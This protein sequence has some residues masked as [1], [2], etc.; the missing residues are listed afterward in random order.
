[1]QPLEAYFA[2]LPNLTS[3]TFQDYFSDFSLVK[4]HNP[5]V[6]DRAVEFWKNVIIETSR[7]GLLG[8]DRC[9]I[10]GPES[11]SEKLEYLET[12]P[13]L[14]CVFQ[15]LY[16]SGLITPLHSFS[17]TLTRMSSSSFLTFSLNSLLYVFIS[18]L[19]STMSFFAPTP[20]FS[21][22]LYVMMPTLESLAQAVDKH[23]QIIT[24][25]KEVY[26]V[27]ERLFTLK[28]FKEECKAVVGEL[29]DKDWEVFLQYLEIGKEWI[30]TTIIDGV[31][32]IKF[33]PKDKT[34]VREITST[35]R[36]IISMKSTRTTLLEQISALEEQIKEA[37]RQAQKYIHRKQRLPALHRLKQ[38]KDLTDLLHKRQE[39]LDTLDDILLR[40]DSAAT[41]AEVLE[42]YDLGR[43]TLSNI[44]KDANITPETVDEK[45]DALRDILAD[46]EE[47]DQ[48]IKESG[49]LS[50]LR[51]DEEELEADQHPRELE[52]RMTNSRKN[53]EKLTRLPA[54]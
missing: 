46:Q 34:A 6:Y 4:K 49:E 45:L 20:S 10:E 21:D 52:E 26:N 7:K 25:N 35:D 47:F 38:K 51:I 22:S 3:S 23:Y 19:R 11:L 44:H 29:S 54:F 8:E 42:A 16:K 27:T 30:I 1:M 31:K 37:Q 15:E 33:L 43:T 17:T 41:D 12:E 53:T 2:N 18:P 48:V 50:G 9:I 40:I 36:G 24:I 32:I 14:D 13:T 28:E 5:E 39:S